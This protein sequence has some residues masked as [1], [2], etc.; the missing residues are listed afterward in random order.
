VR[1]IPAVCLLL[2]FTSHA[3][4]LVTHG[5][6][7]PLGFLCRGIP[8]ASGFR[9]SNL[10][11]MRTILLIALLAGASLPVFADDTKANAPAAKEP[12]NIPAEG[13]KKHIGD[14][15]V[16]TGTI[17]EVSKAE[18]I[19]RLNFDQP[20]PRQ[21][22]TAVVFST[23]TNDFGSFDDLKGKKVEVKGKITA[24]HDRPQIILD[25]TNQLKVLEAAEGPKKEKD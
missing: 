12:V 6:F 14:E 17:A 11:R 3:A 1:A 10:V 9:P 16:V 4:V 18:K 23:K 22:F 21:P 15:A 24:F 7:C 2:E 5:T 25:S 19:V 8:V 13:A 20:F